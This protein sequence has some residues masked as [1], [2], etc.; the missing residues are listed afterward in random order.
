VATPVTDKTDRRPFVSSVSTSGTPFSER[1]ACE[2]RPAQVDGDGDGVLSLPVH[3]VHNVQN[4]QND[5]PS[6]HFAQI[7]QIEQ[8]EQSTAES[9]NLLAT[10]HSEVP[11]D[12]DDHIAELI[13]RP[14]PLGFAPERWVVLCKGVERFA[15]QWAANAMSLGW[16]FEELFA[17][18]E[19]FVNGSLQGAAWFIG[20]KTVTAV[21]AEA[22][23][24]RTE[25]G[26]TLRS[27]RQP[28][29]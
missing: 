17:L 5:R 2:Q 18:R 25:G 14:C 29:G 15:Q 19:P 21:T 9:A 6:R 16:S 23:T 10:L 27:Y 24:L 13:A 22:I 1:H 26:A 7:E 3:N 8:I 20:D 28:R 11:N 4:V 12:W